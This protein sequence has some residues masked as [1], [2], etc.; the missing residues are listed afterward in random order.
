MVDTVKAFRLTLDNASAG[1][2]IIYYDGD[3]QFDRDQASGKNMQE[4][5]AISALADA[6]WD[7]GLVDKVCLVQRRMGKSRWQYLAVVRR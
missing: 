7:A 4:R 5:R 2:P 1:T 3:L 6:A